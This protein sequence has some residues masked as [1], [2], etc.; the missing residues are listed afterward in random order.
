M[1]NRQAKPSHRKVFHMDFDVKLLNK[2]VRHLQKHSV[3]H[4]YPKLDRKTLQIR[5]YADSSHPNN[6][7]LIT[8]LGFIVCLSDAKDNVAIISYRSYKYRRII[9][10]ALAS[11]CHAF[12]DAFDYLY[13]V[14]Y[15]LEQ[16]LQQRI[17]IQM[18]TDSKSLFGVIIR[19][20]K[21]SERRLIIDITAAMEAY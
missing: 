10:S 1:C 3:V 16:L 2:I 4:H 13:L 17:T 9:R 19:A 18:F 5:I 7:D 15:D 20:S 21:N 6:K 8:Q 14:K 11:E 12:A